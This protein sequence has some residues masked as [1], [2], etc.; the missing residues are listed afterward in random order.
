[1][2]PK[3]LFLFILFAVFLLGFAPRRNATPAE[4][5]EWTNQLRVAYGLKALEPNSYLERTAQETADIMAAN[6]M[7]G[8]I[9]GVADRIAAAGYG[10]GVTVYATENIMTGTDLTAEEIVTMAW[11][12]DTHSIPVKNPIYCDIGAGVATDAEGVSY[13]VLHAAY[14]DKRWCGPYISPDGSLLPWA[15][16]AT[17]A[18]LT[19][20]G[21]PKAGTPDPNA[22]VDPFDTSQ[23][24][25]TVRTVTPNPDGVL[26]HEVKFGQS[27]WSIATAYGTTVKAIQ[28]INGISEDWQTVYSGQKLII[29]TSLTPHPTDTPAATHTPTTGQGVALVSASTAT[30]SRAPVTSA[31]PSPVNKPTPPDTD[32][33][34]RTAIWVV[35]GLGVVLIL[36]G[37]L[38][39]GGRSA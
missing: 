8:H 24:I 21:A 11:A 22:T 37:L 13:Y 12:D 26:V 36:G 6:G 39:K 7:T 31:T 25:L 19:A 29:P 1:M 23:W 3:R 27:L 9:G 5:V 33:L 20:T 15:Y 16:T 4:L 28:N 35:A 32:S 17:A 38:L 30:A 2:K 14:S 10:G 18:I 34:V